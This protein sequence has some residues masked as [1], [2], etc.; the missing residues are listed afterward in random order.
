MTT[1]VNSEYGE[2]SSPD[3]Y[4]NELP[5]DP[6]YSDTAHYIGLLEAIISVLAVKCGMHPER[7]M[8]NALM[9]ITKQLGMET[10]STDRLIQA[11][12]RGRNVTQA[13]DVASNALTLHDLQGNPS[14]EIE[15]SAPPKPKTMTEHFADYQMR[16]SGTDVPE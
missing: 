6:I 7:M 13:V 1:N 9:D 11:R 12:W 3:E 10:M 5:Q 14:L 8:G 4:D 16:K 2:I 15:S